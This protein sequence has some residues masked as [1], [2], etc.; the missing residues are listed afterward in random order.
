MVHFQNAFLC[1]TII[2]VKQLIIKK[3][4]RASHNGLRDWN[5]TNYSHL[6]PIQAY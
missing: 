3:F 5:E 4:S 6:T 2:S 1:L